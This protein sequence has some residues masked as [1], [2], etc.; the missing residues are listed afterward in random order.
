MPYLCLMLS[1]MTLLDTM[2]QDSMYW[3]GRDAWDA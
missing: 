2:G 1:P 3:V